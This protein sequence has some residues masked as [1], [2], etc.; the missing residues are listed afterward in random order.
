[1][2]EAHDPI[3]ILYDTYFSNCHL[4]VTTHKWFT[5]GLRSEGSTMKGRPSGATV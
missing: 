3:L 4:F 1:M 5:P 2:T